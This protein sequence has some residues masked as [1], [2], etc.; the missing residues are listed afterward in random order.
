MQFNCGNTLRECLKGHINIIAIPIA[1]TTYVWIRNLA[2][3]NKN[4]RTTM[5]IKQS[6][7][8]IELANGFSEQQPN[9]GYD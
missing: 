9:N 6:N 8:G 7:F 1:T 3:F 2:R 4:V 5:S